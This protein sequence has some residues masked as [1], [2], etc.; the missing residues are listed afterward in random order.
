MPYVCNKCNAV[1]PKHVEMCGACGGF[2]VLF[3]TDE[4]MGAILSEHFTSPCG[5]CQSPFAGTAALVHSRSAKLVFLSGMILSL[6]LLGAYLVVAI[7]WLHLQK[8]PV[9]Y[10]MVAFPAVVCFAIGSGMRKIRKFTCQKCGAENLCPV[11]K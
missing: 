3:V 10:L 2:S 5:S 9:S 7:S 8:I 11:I 6:C 4:V 1:Y